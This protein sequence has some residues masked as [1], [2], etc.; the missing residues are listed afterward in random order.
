MTHSITLSQ[1]YLRTAAQTAESLGMQHKGKPVQEICS[2]GNSFYQV[3][4]A[5]NSSKIVFSPDDETPITVKHHRAPRR[6]AR[7]PATNIT[8]A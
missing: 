8:L 6:H 7:T 2:S 3:I 5:D 1:A 4:Y